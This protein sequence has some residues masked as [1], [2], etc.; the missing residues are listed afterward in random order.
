MNSPCNG[1]PERLE[2][3]RIRD[4]PITSTVRLFGAANELSE[5][6]PALIADIPL[7]HL[8]NLTL[9]AELK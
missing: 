6:Q 1:A 9:R 2:R 3:A 8:L 5:Q 7:A 4:S